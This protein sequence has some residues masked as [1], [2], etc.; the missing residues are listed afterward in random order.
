ML[1][2]AKLETTYKVN[3]DDYIESNEKRYVLLVKYNFLF[4]AFCFASKN[5]N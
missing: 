2:V 1:Y 4:V 3:T 5:F